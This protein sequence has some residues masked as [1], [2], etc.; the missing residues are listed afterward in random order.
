[1]GLGYTQ[2]I[3]KSFLEESPCQ[4]HCHIV[5]TCSYTTWDLN[6]NLSISA[7]HCFFF[8]ATGFNPLTILR[9]FLERSGEARERSPE[10]APRAGHVGIHVGVVFHPSPQGWPS[11]RCL[12]QTNKTKQFSHSFPMVYQPPTKKWRVFGEDICPIPKSRFRNLTIP[13][14]FLFRKG[15]KFRSFPKLRLIFW[16]G[17]KKFKIPGGPKTIK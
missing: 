7:F 11:W 16:G 10:I 6:I 17:F 2:C 12:V 3:S 5:D 9:H 1:M 13:P 4:S 15:G 8:S 14:H